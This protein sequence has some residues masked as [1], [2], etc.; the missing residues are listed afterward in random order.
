[1]KSGICVRFE[2]MGLLGF[3]SS[4]H[5]AGPVLGVRWPSS[6]LD[7]PEGA[8]GEQRLMSR[9][10]GKT[11]SPRKSPVPPPGDPVPPPSP[12]PT[13]W[14]APPGLQALE[15]PN[16]ETKARA[17]RQR[18]RHQ[19]FIG[20]GNLT[21]PKPHPA[22]RGQAAHVRQRSSPLRGEGGCSL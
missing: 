15:L 8:G 10:S 19:W 1:M 4:F 16:L 22:C 9:P 21:R 5:S 18:Q 11:G 17:Q 6:A 20:R 3:F 13:C 14:A 12:G 7:L 2:M